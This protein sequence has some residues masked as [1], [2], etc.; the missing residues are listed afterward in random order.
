M[1]TWNDK[2]RF[3][4]IYKYR[5]HIKVYAVLSTLGILW[6]LYNLDLIYISYLFV[7]FIIS[8]GYVIPIL[9]NHRLRDINYIKIFLIS[10]VWAYISMLPIILASGFTN[11]VL[12]LMLEKFL[13]VMAIT[14]PFD[15]RD[16][17]I[18][19]HNQLRT[20]PDLIGTRRSYILSVMLLIICSVLKILT[21][22]IDLGIVMTI[23]DIIVIAS[24]MLSQKIRSDY[25]Y[26]GLLDGSFLIRL[27]AICSVLG[28]AIF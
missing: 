19:S 22:P 6:S 16:Q 17:T 5:N 23:A 27:V 4:I 14:I 9:S 8:A 7:P 11:T 3:H 25:V 15:I 12:I 10:F 26:S 18:D 28:F 20:I 2:G 21:Y 1:V 13:F 24:I